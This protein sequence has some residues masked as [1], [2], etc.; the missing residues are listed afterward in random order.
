VR[1]VDDCTHQVVVEPVTAVH[2]GPTGGAELVEWL[3][4]DQGERSAEV[5]DAVAAASLAADP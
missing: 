1:D 4:G 2:P 5:G 3:P